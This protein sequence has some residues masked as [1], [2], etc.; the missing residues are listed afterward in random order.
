MGITTEN[1][2]VIVTVDTKKAEAN[3][4]KFD[5][6]IKTSTENLKKL[7]P[8]SKAYN[9]QFI[10]M[11][12]STQG[13]ANNASFNQ[14]RN[15]F[16]G[17]LK[18]QQKF[19]EGTEDWKRITAQLQVYGKKL[20]DIVGR[21]GKFTNRIKGTIKPLK[22]LN[23]EADKSSGL[24]DRLSK[25]G[26]LAFN[27]IVK[28][29]RTGNLS[30][31]A[32]KSAL[33]GTGIGALIVA[34]GELLN[35][36][37]EYK[38]IQDVFDNINRDVERITGLTGTAAAEVTTNVRAISETFGDE[39]SKVLRAA[40]SLT[41]RFGGTTLENLEKI[42]QGY[43]AGANASDQFLDSIIEYAPQAQDA[44]LSTEKFFN[45]LV[46]AEQATVPFDKAID[47]VKE[48]GLRIREQTKP[49]QEA[50]EKA[51]GTEFTKSLFDGINSGSITTEQALQRIITK[52]KESE[53]P[54]NQYQT[55]VADLFA[56]PGEDIGSSFLLSLDNIGDSI[57]NLVD[58]TSV[59]TQAQQQQFEAQQRLAE[60]QNQL[61]LRFQGAFG[62]ADA[63]FTILKTEGIEV[64][65]DIIDALTPVGTFLGRIIQFLRAG[66][67]EGQKFS[68]TVQIIGGT[69]NA[70]ILPLRLLW[71]IFSGGLE[72]L[73][74]VGGGLKVV[75]VT[76]KETINSII[77][78]VNALLPA[79]AQIP[80]IDIPVEDLNKK[81][82]F[83]KKK[84]D[85]FY[86][87]IE[88]TQ[89]S[90]TEKLAL[91]SGQLGK[92]TGEN[93]TSNFKSTIQK[94]A[95]ETKT[96]QQQLQAQ[97]KDLEAQAETEQNIEVKQKLLFDAA[98]LQRQLDEEKDK[99]ENIKFDIELDYALNSNEAQTADEISKQ[100][101]FLQS[102][103][104]Q[105]TDAQV[106][107]D[108]QTKIRNLEA[109][110]QAA[111]TQ[112]KQSFNQSLE[113][114]QILQPIGVS[115]VTEVDTE[116]ETTEQLQNRLNLRLEALDA[117]SLQRKIELQR[118]YAQAY[119][120]IQ[121]NILLDDEQRRLQTK[122]LDEQFQ[123]QLELEEVQRIEKE[124]LFREQLGLIDE[125]YFNRKNQLLEAE[126]D[127]FVEETEKRKAAQD[128][129]NQQQIQ[130]IQ[131]ISGL[132]GDFSGILEDN[133]KQ[134]KEG[135]KQA[136][137]F[138]NAARLLAV[139]Q[140]T[141][142]ITAQLLAVANQAKQ[143]FPANLIAIASTVASVLSA[144]A[145][146]R[147]AFSG[148]AEDGTVFYHKESDT[149]FSK[150]PDTIYAKDGSAFVLTPEGGN[151]T[152]TPENMKAQKGAW[153]VANQG[154]P[155]FIN[156]T[157]SYYSK[158]GWYHK[159]SHK[160]I[161]RNGGI[162]SVAGV[163]RVGQR[164][165][166][167][168]IKMIDGK[169][170]RYLGEWERGEPYM[171]LSRKTY[172]QNR[173]VINSLLYNSINKG[174]ENI[175]KTNPELAHQHIKQNVPNVDGKFELGG[176]VGGPAPGVVNT[177]GPVSNNNDNAQATA[178]AMSLANIES[179]IARQNQ[180][181][182]KLPTVL[183]AYVS[184]SD[185]QE[186]QEELAE[187][188]ADF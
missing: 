134:Y 74:N 142:A 75:E 57:N 34:A 78:D 152:L 109:A 97:I 40:D 166:D 105:T 167:G 85:D 156:K 73:S 169:T 170:G 86:N 27:N 168:G 43:L 98:E 80:T 65:I 115:T 145:K 178:Q 10:Q 188:S 124:I 151:M 108:I 113:P 18:Q 165:I 161:Y 60:A 61:S 176:V 2:N 70:L 183:R 158:G 68:A 88:T 16:N 149:I 52:T 172:F 94:V 146:I 180:L 106:Q 5:A 96:L 125:D 31:G 50:L 147:S 62:S 14:I 21:Q 148:I 36:F 179:A 95:E 42:K 33:I 93:F 6:E 30:L 23:K 159:E 164:H 102:A 7:V 186:A 126:T 63:F 49:A 22:D 32:F 13:F 122:Q 155:Q 127:K 26:V 8:N 120:E 91:T 3:V 184:L 37:R 48:F 19:T 143:P 110:Q 116:G 104:S 28:G 163:A 41:E 90:S 132:F 1:I 153:F 141:A 107:I 174:G 99:L 47:T 4:K 45:V 171:I 81:L 139:A 15:R 121:N 118:N 11:I 66:Q 182:E 123:Q 154:K 51:F 76:F 83:E 140:Q 87:A 79:F 100:I 55:L 101:S 130:D 137:S 54:L 25:R 71:N 181:L 53:L 59:Y 20:D 185:I 67:T 114:L 35:K 112:I 103:L 46:K 39:Y 128:A 12:R 84:V 162:N 133:A 135:S 92:K 58:N 82:E 38:E 187:A 119:K 150:S 77:E 64:L 89:R 175:F 69:I 117:Q 29:I 44:S 177:P 138:A 173:E 136:K 111:Q 56:G 24:F 129:L 160:T 72:I 17:L 144:F 9:E 157:D 131:S